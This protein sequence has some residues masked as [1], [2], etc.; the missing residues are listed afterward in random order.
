MGLAKIDRYS[1]LLP[2]PQ[3][4]SR[5]RAGPA[6]VIYGSNVD[7]SAEIMNP[8]GCV[9][10]PALGFAQVNTPMVGNGGISVGKDRMALMAAIPCQFSTRLAD[11]Y[12]VA[13]MRR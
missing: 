8:N 9:I 13:K 12:M 10:R 5:I 2:D 4:Y 7:P 3:Y 1:G 11:A 6:P